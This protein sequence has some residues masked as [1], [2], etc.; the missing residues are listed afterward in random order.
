MKL[1]ELKACLIVGAF[2][3]LV[4]LLYQGGVFG[5]VVLH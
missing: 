1:T 5:H 3:V 2:I 4:Y